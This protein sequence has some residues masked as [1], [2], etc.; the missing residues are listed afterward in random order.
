VQQGLSSVE[1]KVVEEIA[2]VR[3]AKGG[4]AKKAG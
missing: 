4:D 2:R 1:K 3:D